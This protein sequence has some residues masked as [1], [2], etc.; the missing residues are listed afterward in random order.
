MPVVELNAIEFVLRMLF[1]FP[2]SLL[3]AITALALIGLYVAFKT[4]NS[5]DQKI[6]E[7]VDKLIGEV[8]SVTQA[9]AAQHPG[10]VLV[11]GEIWDA[12]AAVTIDNGKNIKVTGF[13]KPLKRLVVELI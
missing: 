6:D 5:L 13:N 10:K 11:F 4:A 12:E 3:G 9:I 8:G 7:P 2:F 1:T